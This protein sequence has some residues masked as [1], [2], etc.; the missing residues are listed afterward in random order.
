[1]WLM[2]ISISGLAPVAQKCLVVRLSPLTD[3]FTL[4]FI[5]A[6]FDVEYLEKIP[7][8]QCQSSGLAR[9]SLYVK[10]DPLVGDNPPGKDDDVPSCVMERNEIE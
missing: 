5:G 7:I 6:Q 9:Q 8:D 4:L 3:N 10:F 2:L 1:M